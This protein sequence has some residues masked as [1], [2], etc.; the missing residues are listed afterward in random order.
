MEPTRTRPLLWV[1]DGLLSPA[2]VADLLDAV[3]PERLAGAGVELEAS[4]RRVGQTA[5]VPVACH[6]ALAALTE[7]LTR[8]IGLANRAGSTLRLRVATEGDSHPLHVDDYAIGGARLAMT[9]LVYLTA[10]EGGPTRF[11][12]A[13][14][15]LHLP[16]APG[17]VVVW[18][19]LTPD[20]APDR[21]SEHAV[22][23]VLAGRRVTLNWFVYA[24]PDELVAAAGGSP[25]ALVEAFRPSPALTAARALT[26][27]VET[28]T[29][30]TTRDSLRRACAARGL[31]FDEV[32]GAALDPREP[33]LEP[34]AL[35]YRP[36]T[37]W[38]AMRAERQL[39][40]PG[41][42]TFYRGEEGPFGVRTEQ[43]LALAR[44]GLPT[45]AS[46]RLG[47]TDEAVLR[48]AVDA[49]GGLPV[50]VR[51]DDGEGG[52]GVLRADSFAAL[53]PLAEL[54]HSRGH[55]AR[56]AAYVPDAMHWRLVVVGD[57][58][59]TA[60]R[61]P[62]RP[63]DFR[64]EPSG[65]PDDYGLTP[66]PEMAALA[67]RAARVAGSAFAGVD[68]LEHPS[69]RLYVLE[70]NSPCYFP[71]AE[72]W[73]KADVAGAMIDW[74]AGEAERLGQAGA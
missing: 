38:A 16:P 56:L 57:R 35:L 55:A 40:Q 62:V 32:L 74:L 37:S 47:S 67:V 1:L 49:L 19:N 50:V 17:R 73:G 31:R 61:N 36:A 53:R 2:E 5:E 30:D 26:C 4:D 7:R 39:W 58:A 15:P 12:R 64:S 65:S 70:A 21:A 34:G 25:G 3:S 63:D 42:A 6:P 14:P 66:D 68:V 9:A 33:P 29:P 23:P 20:G 52:V 22:G 59:I 41:V 54:L 71:Q 51:L 43:W 8:V 11:P 46:L 13:E 45:P 18:V 60:Y 10:C 24:T 72:A 48:D 69:G 28:G 27:V 44:A